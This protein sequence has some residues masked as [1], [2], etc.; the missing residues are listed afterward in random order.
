MISSVS[1]FFR[2]SCFSRIVDAFSDTRLSI[3]FWIFSELGI[4][5]MPKSW[6]SFFNESWSWYSA[7]CLLRYTVGFGAD[8]S[9]NVFEWLS[10]WLAQCW[11]SGCADQPL[12]WNFQHWKYAVGSPRSLR[13]Y[14]RRDSW[15]S[16]Q[17]LLD[18]SVLPSVQSIH[19][20]LL[21]YRWR[22]WYTGELLWTKASEFSS[23]NEFSLSG[24]EHFLLHNSFREILYV[25]FFC[26]G[27]GRINFFP[28]VK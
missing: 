21:W 7:W 25:K 26:S 18:Y 27:P 3:R 28:M 9:H 8:K 22:Y 16:L 15:T 10:A 24:V 4:L 23:Y 13:D 20:C 12:W 19:D 11:F 14:F 2:N 1:C 6:S 17:L 5:V